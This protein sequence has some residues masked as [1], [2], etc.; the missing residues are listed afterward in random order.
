MA[1]FI[2]NAKH[3]AERAALS[4]MADKVVKDLKTKDKTELYL[5]GIDLA[6]KMWGK[7]YSKEQY[8]HARAVVSNPDNRWMK[9]LNSTIDNA[10]PNVAKM[11][12][13]NFIFEAFI[14]GTKMIRANRVKYGCNIPWLILFD[15]TSACNMHCVGCWSGTYGRKYN[16]SY[17][18]MDKIITEGKELGVYLYLLTGG[19][20]TVR[21]KDI[22][23]LAEKH[24]DAYIAMFTNSTLIDD[25]FCKEVVRLGN[26][27]FLLS[28][29]GTPDT[30]D[31]RRGEGHYAAVMNAMDLFQK[32]GIIF[33][34]SVCYTSQNIEAVTSDEFFNLIASK[35]A[36]YGFY[37]HYMP[38]GS[39]AVPSLMPSVEQR[40]YIIDRIRYIRSDACDV[41]FY[42]MD[43]QNDGEFVNGCIAG[44]RNY[45]HI[46]SVGDA[47]P[48]VFIH[49]SDSNI[50][51]KTILE[52]LQSPLFM[53]YHDGQPFNKNMLRPCPMLENPEIL[54]QLVAKTGAKSTNLES[55]ESA[56]ELTAKTIEYAKNWAP[57]AE[58]EWNN[59]KHKTHTYNVEAEEEKAAE[60]AKAE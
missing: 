24:R 14:R 60:A 54:P 56:E 38:V 36:R 58:Q 40:K 37:F 30:N 9:V 27:T 46:N 31:S 13:M 32:Y 19:E 41:P 22:L 28:I 42:P 26:L 34:T 39:N 33:G 43:F 49:Y 52:M 3:K 20:P 25:D 8:D 10:A 21:K 45:F 55:P 1:S 57:F 44:G 23:K 6:E 17:E 16:L 47:E 2:D 48:C 51:D 53:A 18:D 12:I 59:G 50:H 35:G 4:V 15:P 11:L 29:E 7:D 5:K